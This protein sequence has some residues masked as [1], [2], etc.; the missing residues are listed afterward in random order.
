MKTQAFFAK[1]GGIWYHTAK[2]TRMRGNGVKVLMSG[3]KAAWTACLVWMGVIFTMSA[4][5]GDVSGA[6]SG[7]I[8]KLMLDV[9]TAVTGMRA[10]GAVRYSVEFLVRKGAHMAEYAVLLLLYRRALRLS[11]A[12]YPGVAAFAMCIGYAAT[13]EY[14]QSFVPGRGPAVAD[15]MIDA[16][17]ASIGWA[18]GRAWDF[19]AGRRWKNRT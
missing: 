12:K 9:I 16:A 15:V 18:A 3:K 6:Q 4:M 17:G 1:Y 8:T 7:S 13:D 11:G 10:D 19:M 14:H 5:P 2:N